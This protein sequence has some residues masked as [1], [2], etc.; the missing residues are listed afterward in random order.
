MNTSQQCALVAKKVND[1]LACIRS[2]ARR[3]MEVI[4]ALSSALLRPLVEF[5]VQFWAPTNLLERVL[6]VPAA[7][8]TDTGAS[9]AE[10]L[11]QLVALKSTH[12][13]HS[14]CCTKDSDM[15]MLC[16]MTP[17]SGTQTAMHT[18]PQI[19]S[20][21]AMKI[22]RKEFKNKRGQ[23]ALVG[24]KCI[25]QQL[26]IYDLSC[27]SPYDCIFLHLVLPEPLNCIPF[28]LNIS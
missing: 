23:T 5:C 15:W 21:S 27:L 17:V 4:L 19:Q 22:V 13:S 18:T 10:V 28:P 12:S 6:P 24:F 1:I 3:L 16:G 14:S 8:N 26:F 7:A 20:P 11:L 25:N 9:V 2:A